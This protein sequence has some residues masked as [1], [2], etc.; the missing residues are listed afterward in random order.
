METKRCGDHRVIFTAEKA[1]I[2]EVELPT[3]MFDKLICIY[4]A[5]MSGAPV[6]FSNHRLF[7]F[8]PYWYDTLGRRCRKVKAER[9]ERGESVQEHVMVPIPLAVSAG[10]EIELE[11][12]VP[13][14]FHNRGRFRVIDTQEPCPSIEFFGYDVIEIKHGADYGKLDM[15][16]QRM[17]DMFVIFGT[18]LTTDVILDIPGT[19][20]IEFRDGYHVYHFEA[21]PFTELGMYR[22]GLEGFLRLFVM[23]RR[24]GHLSRDILVETS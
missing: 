21:R 22:K 13:V 7:P 4:Y 24:I 2:Y 20:D 15:R 18:N 16:V 12:S 19:N 11:F 17:T 8:C 14:D 5:D 3:Y 9:R 23:G 10:R 1:H 6:D